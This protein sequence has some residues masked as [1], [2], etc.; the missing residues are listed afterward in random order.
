[1]NELKFECESKGS[2]FNILQD[3]YEQL[4]FF[5]CNNKILNKNHQKD[6][7]MYM[8]CQETGVPPY[9]GDYGEQPK[10]WIEKYHIIKSSIDLRNNMIKEKEKR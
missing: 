10:L 1:M 8:Y 6:I 9:K 4:P 3:I 5:V 2:K 7:A